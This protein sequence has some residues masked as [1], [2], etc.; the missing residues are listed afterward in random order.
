MK[1]TWSKSD[2]QRAAVSI[3]SFGPAE[4]QR[5]AALR[6]RVADQSVAQLAFPDAH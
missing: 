5:I 1:D 3:I 6:E 4:I 2:W